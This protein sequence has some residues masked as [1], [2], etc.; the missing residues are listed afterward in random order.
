[1]KTKKE[2]IQEL[3]EHTKRFAFVANHV[4]YSA[5][6]EKIIDD[7]SFKINYG[8]TFIIMG[9]SGSGKT[10]LMKLLFGLIYPDAGEIFIRGIDTKFSNEDS[11]MELL[12]DME[13]IFQFGSLINN[14][15]IYEN[16]SLMNRYHNVKSEQELDKEI[17]KNLKYF[18]LLH[19]KFVR[20]S[21]LTLSEKKSIGFCRMLLNDFHTIFLDEP[22]ASLDEA[23][24]RKMVRYIKKF[25]KQK[26][27]LIMTTLDIKF[28]F[29][30]A[31][32]IGLL[33]RG[34]LVFFGTVEEL[35]R[36]KNKSV[37]Q[38]VAGLSN[39]SEEHKEQLED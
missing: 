16:I 27:N 7:I 5:G 31:D 17:D 4:K 29:D 24:Q 34:K 28:A 38:L 2:K 12:K 36:N 15:N 6:G 3:T 1:M 25:R 37:K 39:I 14:M 19:R 9:P 11:L 26:K 13:F 35:K 20:P 8:E 22:F 33:D 21:D 23:T 32:K 30:Y 18:N 10:I